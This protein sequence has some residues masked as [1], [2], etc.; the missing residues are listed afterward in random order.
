MARLTSAI[1]SSPRTRRWLGEA[2]SDCGTSAVGTVAADPLLASEKP[3]PAVPNTLAAA[4]LLVRFCVEACLTFDM[5]ASSEI[6]VKVREAASVRPADAARKGLGSEMQKL[7]RVSIHL[8]ERDRRSWRG[9]AGAGTPRQRCYDEDRFPM[10][11]AALHMQD[12]V[13]PNF[14][15]ALAGRNAT[16][17]R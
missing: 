11:H 2:L 1:S 7:M 6:P 12:E 8:D 16:R 17:G 9:A 3:S 14:P 13:R 15:P 10:C 4:A 5:V